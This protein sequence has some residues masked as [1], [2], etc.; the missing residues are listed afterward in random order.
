VRS[1]S[2]FKFV[3]KD[4]ADAAAATAAAA[5]DNGLNAINEAVSETEKGSESEKDK[6]SSARMPT[7]IHSYWVAPH[8]AAPMPQVSRAS[9]LRFFNLYEVK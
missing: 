5:A 4:D 1:T 8:D 7:P 9:F 6:K 3:N 2:H